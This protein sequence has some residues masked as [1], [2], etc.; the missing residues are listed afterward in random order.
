M[1]LDSYLLFKKREKKIK[2]LTYVSHAMSY[3]TFSLKLYRSLN[4]Y[5]MPFNKHSTLGKLASAES[6]GG[7]KKFFNLS[8]KFKLNFPAHDF[9]DL[10]C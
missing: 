8:L 2:P 5:K 1:Q 10:E 6:E 7:V 4:C 9:D 3:E